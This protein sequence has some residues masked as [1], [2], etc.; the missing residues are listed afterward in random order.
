MRPVLGESAFTFSNQRLDDAGIGCVMAHWLYQPT[1][2]DLRGMPAE[3][4]VD[5]TFK[6]D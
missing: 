1:V 6:L 5:V 2:Q 4:Q 3:I